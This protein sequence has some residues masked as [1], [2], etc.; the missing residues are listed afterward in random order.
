MD[1]ARVYDLALRCLAL[2]PHGVVEL[3]RKLRAKGASPAAVAEALER[4]QASGCLN[5]AAFAESLARNR[6]LDRRYGPGRVRLELRSL[7]VAAELAEA[8]LDRLLAETDAIALA[9]SAL[10]KRFGSAPAQDTKSLKK[11]YD[12]LMRRGFD[13]DTIRQVLR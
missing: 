3:G 6:L 1:D 9:R 13:A 8:A 10:E 11:R 12:Y 2:R 4:C 5:D 7:E